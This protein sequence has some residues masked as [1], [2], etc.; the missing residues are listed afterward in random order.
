MFEPIDRTSTCRPY[1]LA[2]WLLS[3]LFAAPLAGLA[4]QRWSPQ[5]YLPP[6]ESFQGALPY[7]ASLCGQA[8]VLALMAGISWRLQRGLLVPDQRRGRLL[9]WLGAGYLAAALARLALGLALAQA[10][11]WFRMWIPELMH[12]VL[13]GF[14][15]TLSLYHRREQ[16]ALW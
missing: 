12:V 2:S 1:A 15:L 8:A 5:P 13:A 10:A 11:P 16:T 6:V 3:G 14:V 9:A 7:W 4:L